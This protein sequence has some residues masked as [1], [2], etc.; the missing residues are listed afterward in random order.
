MCCPECGSTNV[1]SLGKRNFPY[2]FWLL[3]ILPLP[4]AILHQTASP[5]DYRCPTCGL[6][7][8][9]RSTIALLALGAMIFFLAA[10]ALRLAFMFLRSL[11]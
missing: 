11:V 1:E 2:P 3:V 6:R 10:L 8:S 7:F 4:F 9:R 5:I